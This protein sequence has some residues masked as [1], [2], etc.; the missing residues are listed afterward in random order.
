[1]ALPPARPTREV[2]LE[3]RELLAQERLGDAAQREADA[4]AARQELLRQ[5]RELDRQRAALAQR[6][7]EL[8]TAQAQVSVG[9]GEGGLPARGWCSM[10]G[11]LALCFASVAGEPGVMTA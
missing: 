5:Q 6:A 4:S 9:E 11:A 1:M 2:E 10:V 3:G 8:E 7:A